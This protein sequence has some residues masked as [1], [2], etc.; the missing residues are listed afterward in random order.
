MYIFCMG[1]LCAR[2]S[3]TFSEMKCNAILYLYLVYT[4]LQNCMDLS[5]IRYAE[6]NHNMY[7][8]RLWFLTASYAS[9]AIHRKPFAQFLGD[10]VIYFIHKCIDVCFAAIQGIALS[11]KTFSF[12][13]ILAIRSISSPRIKY[14]DF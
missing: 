3:V 1:S 12:T 5:I 6:V 11:S 7:Y 9:L 10:F 14:F 4:Y 2:A 8:R 13:S